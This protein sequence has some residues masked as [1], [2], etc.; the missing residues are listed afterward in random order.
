M[1][2]QAHP[3]SSLLISVEYRNVTR[4]LSFIGSPKTMP[5]NPARFSRL[6]WLCGRQLP[7][8]P[9]FVDSRDTLSDMVE[10][11]VIVQTIA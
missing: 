10:F 11:P 6:R 5:W 4:L 8:V 2:A 1:G 9:S 3:L 7:P